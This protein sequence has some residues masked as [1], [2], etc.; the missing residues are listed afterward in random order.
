MATSRTSQSATGSGVA[1]DDH[2]GQDGDFNFTISDLLANDGGSVKDIASQF[3]FGTTQQ[4][5]DHQEQYL[6]D[7][8]ITYNAANHTYTITSGADDFQYMIQTGNKG[9]WS[10]ANVDV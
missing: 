9:T 3:K 4:E 1:K 10:T 2:L 7:H 6:A 8:G 5:W